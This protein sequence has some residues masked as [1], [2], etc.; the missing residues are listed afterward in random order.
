MAVNGVS[1][2]TDTNSTSSSTSKTA[3]LG[4]EEFLKLLVTQLQNQDP[5]EPMENTEF[6]SQMANF[7]ALEQMTSINSNLE[8]LM[9]NLN[10]DLFPQLAM[11]QAAN[12][13]GK[14]VSYVNS[15]AEYVT[16]KVDSIYIT[17]G[18]ITYV[19][20]G[21]EISGSSIIKVSD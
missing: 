9:S 11:Q 16:G 1:G 20:D 17:D 6:I 5:L 3:S 13:I 15:S 7:S 21:K 14:E 18:V 10:E 4:Q 12:L 8:T 19:V 2:T